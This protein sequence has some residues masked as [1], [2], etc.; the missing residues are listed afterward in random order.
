MTS[1]HFT[2]RERLRSF[3]NAFRGIGILIQS[4]HN[5]WIHAFATVAVITAGILWGISKEEW[6]GIILAIVVVWVAEALN[7]AFE[8]LAD[9]ANPSFHPLV[10]NAKDIAAGAVLLAAIGSVVIGVMIFGPHLAETIKA[11]R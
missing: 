11:I 4:Q 8:F 2:C 6:T 7:T 5:A 9:A 3:R 1:K 10:K